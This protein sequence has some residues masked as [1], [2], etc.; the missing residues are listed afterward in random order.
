[1]PPKQG[2][3]YLYG[4]APE[5][6]Q[7]EF[8]GRQARR[9]KAIE[10]ALQSAGEVKK[11]AEELEG[12]KAQGLADFARSEQDGRR[13]IRARAADALAAAQ[14]GGGAGG[15]SSYGQL[16]QAGK[17]AGI[18]EA[19]FSAGIA[20]DKTD[21]NMGLADRIGSARVA[22]ADQAFK[23]LQVEQE[24]GTLNEDRQQRMADLDG[25]INAILGA[26]KGFFNDDEDTAAMQIE[27]LAKFEDDPQMRSYLL[28]R[29][30]DIR[31]KSEDF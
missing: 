10:L 27:R 1:M 17:S 15:G 5:E 23:A 4:I 21:F 12:F 11:T 6:A 16:L 22:A 26:Q 8:E 2:Q 24:A 28:Q 13:G 30:R 29:A 25:Q 18:T 3:D 19:D 31:N 14:A 20:R 9:K 7:S